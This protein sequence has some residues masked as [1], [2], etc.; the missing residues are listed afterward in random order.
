MGFILNGNVVKYSRASEGGKGLKGVAAKV[1]H[2][3]DK[4]SIYCL[5]HQTRDRNTP[6]SK[7]YRPII[8]DI[9]KRFY[10]K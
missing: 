6:I 9:L 7:K 5:L 4:F 3:L 2:Q 8:L 10:E 1:V